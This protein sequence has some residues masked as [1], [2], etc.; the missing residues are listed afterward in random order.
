M[1]EYN[2]QINKY[3]ANNLG[4][5]QLYPQPMK[6]AETHLLNGSDPINIGGLGVSNPN[7]LDN[8]YWASPDA[9][10]DQRG[11]YIQIGGT[12]MYKDPDFTEVFGP[13]SGTTPVVMYSTYARPIDNGIE[14]SLYIKKSDC[15]RGYTGAGYTID[16]W[17]TTGSGM[18]VLIENDG[19]TV[20]NTGT[21]TGY[22][23]QVKE[24]MEVGYYAASLNVLSVSGAV[25]A[26]L[27]NHDTWD[28]Q[29]TL[30]ISGVGV[31]RSVLTVKD[32]W[33]SYSQ[34]FEIRL[35]AGASVKLKA[36][37]L[38]LGDHQTIAHQENGVWVLNEIPDY[39]EQ[40]ARCQRCYIPRSLQWCTASYVEGSGL[41]VSIPAV[42]RTTPVLSDTTNKV[43]ANDTWHDVSGGVAVWFPTKV[44]IHYG[45]YD[46]ATAGN[47][48]LV[49]RIPALSADM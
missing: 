47:C 31:S 36:V 9:I 27:R 43:F 22:F 4:Y 21:E 20:K 16:R 10:I 37:K 5:D 11:G 45:F 2:V 14:L 38:E 7:L 35:A 40:L 6:H 8:S 3:N 39:G 44:E 46:W 33:K 32:A 24:P 25:D 15:V 19:I 28:Y 13:S 23:S 17:R 34:W 41:I 30:T 48:Y 1:A 29:G 18:V 49:D 26:I 42:M 12:M